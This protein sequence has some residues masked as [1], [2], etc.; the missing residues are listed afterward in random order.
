MHRRT[1]AGV[2][3]L[4]ALLVSAPLFSTSAVAQTTAPAAAP[5][6]VEAARQQ[7]T[8]L[9]KMLDEKLISPPEY[10]AA[11]A[12]I[13]ASIGA[14]AT[15]VPA[16]VPVAVPAP[17][18]A[19]ALVPAPAPPPPPPPP[20]TVTLLPTFG[21]R[22][23]VHRTRVETLPD[24]KLMETPEGPLVWVVAVNNGTV[25]VQREEEVVRFGHHVGGVEL[26]PQSVPSA[27]MV[28]NTLTFS[29]QEQNIVHEHV[30]TTTY[31]YVLALGPVD[32]LA[33]TYAKDSEFADP[34]GVIKS[35]EGG[36]VELTRLP[37]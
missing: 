27:K 1:I 26:I 11:R 25:T 21:G 16:P 34:R 2:G 13:L 4:T 32:H 36:N 30:N 37:G 24:G 28:G 18:P 23:S 15:A 12:K 19:A 7:L 20:P 8:T 10:E 17:A 14:D 6:N 33:G 29:I 3:V 5:D 35:H 9:Q 22:W 31:T